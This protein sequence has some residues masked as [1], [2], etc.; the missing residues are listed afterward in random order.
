MS[1]VRVSSPAP[2]SRK[3]I[4]CQ[5]RSSGG[6]LRPYE[7][8]DGVVGDRGEKVDE[9]AIGRAKEEG[10]DRKRHECR[11][12]LPIADDG[13]EPLVLSVDIVNHP[14]DDRGLVACGAGR[15]VEECRRAG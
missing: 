11:L 10:T 5:V 6:P 15:V 1:R 14:L 8:L 13:L 2:M 9:V 3:P 4:S 7:S 12:L